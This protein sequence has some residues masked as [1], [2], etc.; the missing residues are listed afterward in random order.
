MRRTLFSAAA[1][2]PLALLAAAPAFAQVTISDAHTTP[3]NT[4]TANNGQPSDVSITG[5]V[6]LTTPGPAVVLDSSNALTNSGAISIKD[7]DGAT[8]VQILGGHTGSFAN[9]GSITI[10]ESYT[11]TDTN[12]DGVVDGAYAQG[13]GRYGLRLIG[14]GTFTGNITLNTG[15]AIT[16]QGNNS[17]GV[18]L[19]A[20]MV[21]NVV[22]AGTVSL[23]GTNTVA[24][25]HTIGFNET[26]GVTGGLLF[27]GGVSATGGGAQAVSVTGNVSGIFSI[28]SAIQ[29][30]G[31]RQT[32]RSTDP[33]INAKLLPEDLLTSGPALTVGGNVGGGVF[34]G[35]PPTGTLSTDTT[36]DADGDGLVD[37]AEGTSTVTTFGPGPAMVI[38]ATGRD[39][40]L[41]EFGSGQNTYGLIIEGTVTGSGVFDGFGGQ[42]LQIGT[43]DGTVH[44]DG[45]VKIVGTVTSQGYQADSTAVHVMSGVT[46]PE[47]RNQ[48]ATTA[49]AIS[50]KATSA[51]ALVL[52]PGAS[53]TTLTNTGTLSAVLNGDLGSAYAV[54]DNS[55]SISKVTNDNLISA[56]ITPATVTDKT[57]GSTV[58]LDLSHNTTGVSIIQSPNPNATTAVPINPGIIGDVLLGS[59]ND[60]VQLLAGGIRGALSFDGGQDSF[61]VD[62]GASYIGAMTTTPTGVLNVTVNKGSLEDDS[63]ST[64]HATSLSVGSSGTLIVSADPANNVATHFEV[65]GPVTIADGTLGLHLVSLLT[66]P[67][68]YTVISTTPGNLNVGSGSALTGTTPYLY[69]TSF[70][71]DQSAGTVSVNV[72]RRSA[73]E[74][75]LNKAETA[76]FDPIY[77]ALAL[78]PDIQKAFLAQTTQAGLVSNMDQMMPDHAGDVFRAL[79]WASE[80]VGVAAGEPPIGQDQQGPTRAWTQEI[81]LSE[82]KDTEDA[83]GYNALGFGAV[84]GIESVSAKGDALGVKVGFVTANVS[85]PSLPSNNLLGVSELTAGA[86]WRGDLGPVRADAQ[87]GAGFI[88]VN[89]H[90]EFLFTDTDEVIHRSAA[91]NWDGYSLS[92]RL[93]LEYTANI[94]SF[95]LEPRVHADYFRLHEGG[96]TES[97]GGQGFDLVVDGRTG[98]IFTVTGSVVAGTTF[99][100]TGFRWRPQIEVGYRAVISGSAGSTT[101]DFAGTNDPFTMASES[102][103]EG[104]AIGRVGLHIYAN[105]LDLLLDAGA[106]YN[107]DVTDIDVHLTA[108][109]VF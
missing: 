72:R 96:Y 29:S 59:G 51:T 92:A 9:S 74:A 22:Q 28:Y 21:G 78:D 43:G 33:T 99:G 27:T 93:G 57:T 61:L 66:A 25:A 63:A 97:G 70:D 68:S 87:L 26:G 42:A 64:I 45:G 36:T 54:V 34:L 41:G 4:S 31:Y 76:A 39:V 46:F 108:R 73:A 102:L 40:H 14:P 52:D 58:A 106:Q 6:T 38:G 80:Q 53:V 95:F 19:E 88:W 82:H 3:V 105:Y 89:N 24:G 71:A 5:T 109:T 90:R 103:R 60:N 17:Y 1:A 56:T 100:S 101:A 91:S 50:S 18:S 84:G 86:Y 11:P 10:N 81:V 104:S 67:A 107:K 85:N 65:T 16:V 2:A 83:A 44:I 15:S 98:D 77:N 7:V 49:N 12:G 55:G 30:T 62:G 13:T 32:V 20:P 48:G 94:G 37:S 69:I 47:Y 79:N 23:T 8:G 35:A 75:G